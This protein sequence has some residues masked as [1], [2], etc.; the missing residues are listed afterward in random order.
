MAAPAGSAAHWRR[1]RRAAQHLAPSSSG[2]AS[3]DS[4]GEVLAPVRLGGPRVDRGEGVFVWD[5]EGNRYIDGSG[6]P[7]GVFCL[8]HAHPE[9]TAA[10]KEQLDRIAFGYTKYFSSDP[11]AE[12]VTL[13]G[14]EAG[15]GHAQ[16]GRTGRS[17]RRWRRR[18]CRRPVPWAVG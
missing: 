12:L 11:A 4:S 14:E 15:G 7:A 13:I 9:V 16:N 1:L 10:T 8:G 6:G 5:Q 17:Q 18:Y 2:A 3:A